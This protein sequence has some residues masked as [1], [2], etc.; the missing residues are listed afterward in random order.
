[1]P[2]TAAEFHQF[3]D[4]LKRRSGIALAENKQYLVA[5]RLR[6]LI[7]EIG[8]D[9]VSDLLT[10]I[11]V[12]PSHDLA[13]K[14]VDAI[15]TNESFWFRDASHF[16]YLEKKL[17][18][19][20]AKKTSSL[21]VWSI[22][23]SSGEEAYSIS[24]SIDKYMEVSGR[25]INAKVIATDCSD[26][27]LNKAKAGIYTHQE[28]SR[29][30][31]NEIREEH[32]SGVRGGLQISS[33]HRSRVSFHPLNLLDSFSSLGQFDI[34]FCR[35]VLPYF[36]GPCKSD[37]LNRI[38]NVMKPEAFLFLGCSEN[39]PADIGHLEMIR[40]GSCQFYRKT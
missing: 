11:S 30:L 24:L 37:I 13:I 28:L 14:A 1:M 31:P 29:G 26:K 27:V 10:M 21:A 40:E 4:F 3:K 39:A 35:D 15:T 9:R 22:A 7:E 17:L 34:I 16:N 33:A 20:F 5:N 25:K 19:K 38:V 23:C 18:A 6:P 12:M 36:A 8:I 2:I 32:F